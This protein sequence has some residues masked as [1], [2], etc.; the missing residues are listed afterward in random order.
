MFN[1]LKKKEKR[2]PVPEVDILLCERVNRLEDYVS[3][4]RDSVSIL[5]SDLTQHQEELRLL[6]DIEYKLQECVEKLVKLLQRL[7]IA[8]SIGME[9]VE[10]KP[11]PTNKETE[12]V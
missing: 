5:E 6:R 9:A 4:M 11:E 3:K 12:N 7:R 1:W 8:F 10:L 2:N